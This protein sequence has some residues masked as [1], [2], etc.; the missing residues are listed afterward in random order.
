MKGKLTHI[1]RFLQLNLCL[2]FWLTSASNFPWIFPAYI[3]IERTCRFLSMYSYL[4]IEMY[5]CTVDMNMG[6][7]Q[8]LKK[9]KFNGNSHLA[10][11]KRDLLKNSKSEPP[12]IQNNENQ[13]GLLVWFSRLI[14]S[15]PPS[16]MAYSIFLIM[17]L[18][19][20]NLSWNSASSSLLSHVIWTKLIPVKTELPV[21]SQVVCAVML[22]QC[23][24]KGFAADTDHCR[25]CSKTEL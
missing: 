6:K 13:Y 16:Y 4:N 2:M 12:G 5:F 3:Q 18:W 20:C 22:H 9:L 24:Q 15:P 1:I 11:A 7:G 8:C 14:S 19:S 23:V 10:V 17:F 25:S 21:E